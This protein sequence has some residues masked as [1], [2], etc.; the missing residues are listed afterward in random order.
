MFILTAQDNKQMHL[1]H[2]LVSTIMFHASFRYS[3][4]PIAQPSCKPIQ[5]LLDAKA[6]PLACDEKTL[7]YAA[8]NNDKEL[9]SLLVNYFKKEQ[10]LKE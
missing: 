4:P 5:L 1:D 8:Q 7:L 9:L 6:N 10:K 3:D 2:A